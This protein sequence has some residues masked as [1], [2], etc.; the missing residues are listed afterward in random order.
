MISGLID[1]LERRCRS[2][3]A[4][5]IAL[6]QHLALLDRRLVEGVDAEK[7]RGDD[8]LQHEM[9]EQFAEARLVE[10]GELEG[11]HRAAVLRQRLGGGAALRGDEVADGFA[12]EPGSPAAAES[13]DRGG[14]P[15]P[16]QATVITVN[17]LS[18][19]PAM[20]S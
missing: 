4:G 17:S 20:K 11:A 12:R 2:R 14:G 7:L 3:T 10:A 1:P 9:H 5:Q 15:S 13:P 18:R 6:R 16:A 8:R 19:G